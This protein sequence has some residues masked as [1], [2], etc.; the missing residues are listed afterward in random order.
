MVRDAI[1]AGAEERGLVCYALTPALPSRV[2]LELG[3]F[4]PGDL[5]VAT[6]D[7][8]LDRLAAT[9]NRSRP[10]RGS[11]AGCQFLARPHSAGIRHDGR[12]DRLP[13]DASA[14]AL[15]VPLGRQTRRDHDRTKYSVF[16]ARLSE[17]A[18][19][20]LQVVN[21]RFFSMLKIR[22]CT[23]GRRCSTATI[24]RCLAVSREE[25]AGRM[26]ASHFPSI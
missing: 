2:W 11:S 13:A 26:K 20:C 10:A 5:D 1:L 3:G 12:R 6:V 8:A 23:N 21:G 15:L 18:S 24:R 17:Q 4:R 25:D 7:R 9:D 19:A 22:A 14:V 16:A